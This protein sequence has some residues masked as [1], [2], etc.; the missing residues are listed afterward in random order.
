MKLIEL[1]TNSGN[2]IY[3][4]PEMVVCVEENFS[5]TE[6]TVVGGKIIEVD[7]EV[8]KV[9]LFISSEVKID[10]ECTKQNLNNISQH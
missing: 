9:A 4:N 6:I 8:D 5:I 7:T 10:K 2:W 1:K 3:I